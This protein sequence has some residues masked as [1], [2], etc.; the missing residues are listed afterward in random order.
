MG[1]DHSCVK[2]ENKNGFASVLVEILQRSWRGIELE[3]VLGLK[4]VWR[5]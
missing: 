1:R 4:H 2:E 3:G 5:V